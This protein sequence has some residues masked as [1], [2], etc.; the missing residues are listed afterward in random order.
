MLIDYMV[1]LQYNLSTHIHVHVIR[2]QAIKVMIEHFVMSL[3]GKQIIGTVYCTNITSY[4]CHM[5]ITSFGII[6]YH[7]KIQ[8]EIIVPV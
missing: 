7:W 8:N 2:N 5:I 1:K 6:S 3:F 4:R